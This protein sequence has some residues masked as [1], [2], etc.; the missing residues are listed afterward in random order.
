M[1]NH[2]LAEGEKSDENQLL[3]LQV[4]GFGMGLASPFLKNFA[5]ETSNQEKLL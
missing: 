4:G 1:F 2:R 3:A 5:T